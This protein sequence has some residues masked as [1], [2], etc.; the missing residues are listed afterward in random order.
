MKTLLAICLICLA[1]FA[2]A[3]DKSPAVA[4]AAATL[5]GEVLEITEVEPYTYLRLKTKTGEVWAAVGQVPLKKGATVTIEDVTT[6]RN[7]ESKSLKR[8]F[9][10][11][12][13][14]SV[15]GS[16][17]GSGMNAPHPVPANNPE[18]TGEIKV[19]R[20]TGANARTVA[21]IVG[22][23]AALKDK[24]VVVR[25]KVV[26][27]NPGIMGKNWVHLQD[28]SGS[29]A[30]NTNDL[31]VTTTSATKLGDIVTAKG[32]VRANKDFGGGYAYKVLVEDATLQP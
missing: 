29:A 3:G 18:A 2:A 16:R 25:G 4:S 17:G 22:K 28:G 23:G 6:M 1:S 31:L 5:T 9:E 24:P 19:P 15:A 7:F 11:I 14:G 20:A 21:E 30:D 27:Y 32:T 26:K 10:T 8:T 12:H 13:F